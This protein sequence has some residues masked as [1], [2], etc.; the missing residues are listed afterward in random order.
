MNDDVRSGQDDR[1]CG[2]TGGRRNGGMINRWEAGLRVPSAVGGRNVLWLRVKAIPVAGRLH[3]V[4][5]DGTERES[6]WQ[7]GSWGSE[8]NFAR[9][10]HRDFRRWWGCDISRGRGQGMG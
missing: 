3:G 9:S 1:W 8:R 5:L 4:G 2:S 10:D 6:G 7:G